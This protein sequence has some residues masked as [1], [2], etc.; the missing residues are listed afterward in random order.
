MPPLNNSNKT[1]VTTSRGRK[2]VVATNNNID[3]KEN[4]YNDENSDANIIK[5]VLKPTT[6]KVTTATRKPAATKR[7]TAPIVPPPN[8]DILE[9]DSNSL[10]NKIKIIFEDN[11][12]EKSSIKESLNELNK[13]Y[14][15]IDS[16]EELESIV[17]R[18]ID[19]V[20]LDSNNMKF[21]NL[22]IPFITNQLVNNNNNNNN[23]IFFNNI[24]NHLIE[25]S[26]SKNIPIRIKTIHL[27]QLIISNFKEIHQPIKETI[28]INLINCLL[29]KSN[30]L[31]YKVRL[32]SIYSISAIQNYLNNIFLNN[33]NIKSNNIIE[34]NCLVNSRLVEMLKS[35]KSIEIKTLV[36]KTI[37]S[38]DKEST[39]VILEST[40]ESCLPVRRESFSTIS[41]V[42]NFDD[43]SAEKRIDLLY[44]GL[45]DIDKL[46]KESCSK[47]LIENWLE[48]S[49]SNNILIFLKNL[50]VCLENEKK[51]ELILFEIFS[52]GRFDIDKCTN[53]KLVNL[54]KEESIHLRCL[55]QFL[56]KQKKNRNDSSGGDDDQDI[57]ESI[58]SSTITEFTSI[59]LH[60]LSIDEKRKIGYTYEEILNEMTEIKVGN[61]GN[62]SNNSD[63]E[64]EEKE[65]ANYY[66]DEDLTFIQ[67][68]LI[69]LSH[70]L[71]FSDE[72]GRL[73]LSDITQ[74]LL[75]ST[76]LNDIHLTP[77]M[78][79]LFI[80]HSNDHRKY[81]SIVRTSL[82]KVLETRPDVSS[83]YEIE[84]EITQVK[85]E[86]DYYTKKR[87]FFK[88]KLK[89]SNNPHFD[90]KCNQKLLQY[91]Q[92]L[93][94]SV[95]KYNEIIEEYNSLI[96]FEEKF[97][98]KLS[99][100]LNNFIK[101]I[102]GSLNSEIYSMTSPYFKL[103]TENC[104]ND[105][106]NPLIIKISIENIILQSLLTRSD[107]LGNCK[108]LLNV[109]NN[110]SDGNNDQDDQEKLNIYLLSIQGLFD[111]LLWYGSNLNKKKE[112]EEGE[113][114]EN[115]E[116]NLNDEEIISFKFVFNQ[117]LHLL[118]SLEND[119]VEFFGKFEIELKLIEGFS[120]LLY[121]QVYFESVT[122]LYNNSNGINSKQFSI[123]KYKSIFS[124]LVGIYFNPLHKEKPIQ[125]FLVSFFSL[126]VKLPNPSNKERERERDYA[127]I[128]ELFEE[129]F[130][131]SL[132]IL[133]KN[134]G[135]ASTPNLVKFYQYFIQNILNNQLKLT[136]NE[137]TEDKEQHQID[138][139]QMEL[140]INEIYYTLLF[141]L[142]LE[143]ISDPVS[144][145]YHCKLFSLF[146]LNQSLVSE[147]LVQRLLF[148]SEKMQKEITV[149]T[150]NNQLIKYHKYLK[151]LVSN[152]N[153]ST[154]SLNQDDK[155]KL[156]ETLIQYKK[157]IHVPLNTL[158]RRNSTRK[159]SL[160]KPK[161][162]DIEDES[163]ESEIEN[164][165]ES[166][167]SQ[168]ASDNE[169]EEYEN[170]DTENVL[171]ISTLSI[172]KEKTSNLKS[173]KKNS[174]IF[175]SE[176][177]E[178]SE[179]E[180][181]LSSQS[182]TSESESSQ[183]SSD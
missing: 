2:K 104:V 62:D 176:S 54:S 135:V 178:I 137:N 180:S 47:M 183:E 107:L 87:K 101:K 96:L 8:T 32:Q 43:I 23:Q 61:G 41:R 142:S 82:E 158:S 19:L 44:N 31:N 127:F 159:S 53:Y 80:L 55:V 102:N 141:N 26:N 85:N 146:Q 46:V 172:S 108:I 170:N 58:L 122:D 59:L 84:N 27:I 106:E 117:L 171:D 3:N 36:L 125:L 75:L 129:S 167:I 161:V 48:I 168:I 38:I 113:E 57:F 18:I 126:L 133:L 123:E 77:L 94:Q 52:K 28:I 166:E 157:N 39:L 165:S 13:L 128:L 175:D 154:S 5:T 88:D 105:I 70:Y 148:L 14:K 182:S 130:I 89:N 149:K 16:N 10:H 45:Q 164:E 21:L 63:N 114:E 29:N 140:K 98:I 179:D 121:N 17:F 22:L 93:V 103:I 72:A 68:Q 76:F 138:N 151:S 162:S 60:Y 74:K 83:I 42:I 181:N 11:L 155:I 37:K 35:D 100:I 9:V 1:G 110:D 134:S 71:D 160:K 91:K 49:S 6:R 65:D 34:L 150:Y 20:L 78:E 67:T 12:N 144:N 109:L 139:N 33:N 143:I 177:E 111:I 69:S 131:S 119:S 15:S 136:N 147:E 120:K 95:S 56:K 153:E 116:D 132:Q 79:L 24:T 51:I 25:R 30:D 156:L 145:K 81:L 115:E 124:V 73:F 7:K 169:N 66:N 4:E 112:E 50:N 118:K 99:F 86:V 173:N 152:D 40:L 174:K 92:N 97:W 64:N 90:E 163:S